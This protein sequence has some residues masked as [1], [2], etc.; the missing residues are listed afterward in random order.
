MESL[1]GRNVDSIGK[2]CNDQS[3]SISK[4][5]VTVVKSSIGNGEEEVVLT[6]II[7]SLELGLPLEF[8]LLGHTFSVHKPNDVSGMGVHGNEAHDL[9][10]DR[11]R[12]IALHHHDELLQGVRLLLVGVLKGVLVRIVLGEGFLNQNDPG[13]AVD[14]KSYLGWVL[15]EPFS[16]GRFSVSLE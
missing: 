1:S 6:R 3:G 12:E 14:E 5:L 9:L 2:G 8:L 7:D 16:L 11:L 13:A 10:S 15:D 4:V